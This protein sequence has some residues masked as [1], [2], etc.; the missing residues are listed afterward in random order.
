MKRSLATL[1]VAT[2]VGAG[3]ALAGQPAADPTLDEVLERTGR[4]VREFER[5]LS[6]IVAEEAYTQWYDTGV[7]APGRFRGGLGT[8]RTL[9]SDFLLVRSNEDE[10][11]VPFRDVFEVDGQTIREREDRLMKLFVEAPLDAFEQARRISNESTRYN[12]GPVR[13]TVNV[14]TLPLKFL[15]PMNQGRLNFEKADEERMDGVRVWEVAFHEVTRP[16]LIRTTNDRS[17]PAQGAFW[18]DPVSGAVLRARLKLDVEDLRSEITVTYVAAERLDV[19]VPGELKEQYRGP[20]FA[21][22][23]TAS[24]G[25]LR[26]FQVI[27]NEQID[28]AA[29]A[30]GR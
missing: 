9:K 10:G 20:G 13:R 25:R 28:D 11:W 8:R 17:L 27:T 4:Y 1:L 14:P 21:L 29:T 23:G 5:S 18:I 3:S 26:R 7:G 30:E 24:Y 16:T 2:A 12:I 19:R 22:E 6:N 15:D